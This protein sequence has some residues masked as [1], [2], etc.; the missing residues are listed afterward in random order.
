M[1]TVITISLGVALL[2]WGPLALEFAIALGLVL[3]QRARSRLL[4]L[5]IGFHA[6]IA[7]V[8]GLVSFAI[9][10]CAALILFLPPTRPAS[11]V[12]GPPP[13]RLFTLRCGAWP[14]CAS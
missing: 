2:T 13:L 9:A 14:R 8:I 10:M 1:E 4:V 5:G 3:D 7:V 12:R 6:G 11:A